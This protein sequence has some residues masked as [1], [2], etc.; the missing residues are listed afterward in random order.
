MSKSK[1]N[2][3]HK[4]RRLSDQSVCWSAVCSGETIR[5]LVWTQRPAAAVRSGDVK[6][7]IRPTAGC[8]HTRLG[9]I[10]LRNTSSPTW[11]KAYCYAKHCLISNFDFGHT[12]FF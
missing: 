8:G 12:N 11:T 2:F 5:E 4:G 10:M 9:N 6:Q 7:P 3:S 1:P